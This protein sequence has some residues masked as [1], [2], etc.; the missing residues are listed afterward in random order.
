G[1][2]LPKRRLSVRLSFEY[3][4]RL[5]ARRTFVK[6]NCKEIPVLFI[7]SSLVSCLARLARW[8]GGGRWRV[9]AHTPIFQNKPFMSAIHAANL[10]GDDHFIARRILRFFSIGPANA[11][12]RHE[13]ERHRH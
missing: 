8:T 10:R 4:K 7:A 3:G 5:Q 9:A 11:A 2:S 13:A 12:R 6:R 1:V